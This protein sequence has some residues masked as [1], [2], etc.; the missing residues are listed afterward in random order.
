MLSPCGI[1][2]CSV[3][4][5]LSLLGFH[6]FSLM[7]VCGEV[8]TGREYQMVWI[9]CRRFEAG[10]WGR[11]AGQVLLRKSSDVS[12]STSVV[13]KEGEKKRPPEQIWHR[14]TTCP[15]KREM[16]K[17][18]CQRPQT[19]D[20]AG[21]QKIWHLNSDL[22]FQRPLWTLRCDERLDDLRG[23]DGP[24]CLTTGHPHGRKMSSKQGQRAKNP[25]YDACLCPD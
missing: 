17:R 16:V 5:V 22:A 6:L 7:G 15:P 10:G 21:R 1:I 20:D 23:A 19:P 18:L 3:A 24:L 11:K 4:L 8:A 13:R 12:R 9:N 2:F 14:A 25:R